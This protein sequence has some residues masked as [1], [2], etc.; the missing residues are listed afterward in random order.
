MDTHKGQASHSHE[1]QLLLTT[2]FLHQEL[3]CRHTDGH[4]RAELN[5]PETRPVPGMGLSVFLQHPGP[6]SQQL[7]FAVE[8]KEM[9]CPVCFHTVS[10]I[11]KKNLFT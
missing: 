8:L 6:S 2:D 9:P 11:I 3:L 5:L 10:H 7:L 1:E 4:I